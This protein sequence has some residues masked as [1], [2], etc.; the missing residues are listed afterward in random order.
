MVSATL[1]ALQWPLDALQ[2]AASLFCLSSAPPPPSQLTPDEVVAML[3]RMDS[4]TFAFNR[5]NT[6]Y[7]LQLAQSSEISFKQFL[8][9]YKGVE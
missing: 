7:L 1:E 5:E 4:A 2:P 6:Q 9:W 8:L 3:S